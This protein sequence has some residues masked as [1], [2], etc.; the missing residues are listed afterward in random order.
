MKKG[1]TLIE[2]VIAMAVT[3][4]LLSALAIVFNSAMTVYRISR[5]DA[6]AQSQLRLAVEKITIDIRSSNQ[7][8]DTAIVADHDCYLINTTQRYCLV[9]TDLQLNSQ[10]LIQNVAQFTISGPPS[11]NKVTIHLKSS[12]GNGKEMTYEIYLRN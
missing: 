9:G 11:T 3:T 4:I 1:M 5:N 7:S 12:I 6:Q 10:T 2:L 8:L